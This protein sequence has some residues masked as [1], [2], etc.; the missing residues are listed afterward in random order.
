MKSIGVEVVDK[1]NPEHGRF[2]REPRI[3][4]N[5][6][7]VMGAFGVVGFSRAPQTATIYT[8]VAAETQVTFE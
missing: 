1:N 6:Q 5:A 4:N 8:P 2:T 3:N 7:P